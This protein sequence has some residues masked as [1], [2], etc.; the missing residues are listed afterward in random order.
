MKLADFCIENGYCID[1]TQAKRF[2]MQNKVTINGERTDCWFID[3]E[4]DDVISIVTPKSFKVFRV[5]Q[6]DKVSKVCYTLYIGYGTY[7]GGWNMNTQQLMEGYKNY[8]RH[9]KKRSENTIRGYV[10]DLKHFLSV[11]KNIENITRVEILD[12]VQELNKTLSAKL[13]LVET[14]LFSGSKLIPVYALYAVS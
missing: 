10:S 6:L 11:T 8:L 1:R 9:T 14:A 3:L 12:Y 2:L 7:I 13:S 4:K 5:K